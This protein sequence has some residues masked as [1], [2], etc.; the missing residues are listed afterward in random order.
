MLV[1]L[2]YRYD[3]TAVVLFW[4]DVMCDDVVWVMLLWLCCRGYAIDNIWL[5]VFDV[6]ICYDCVIIVSCVC[7]AVMVFMFF[8]RWFMIL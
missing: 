7:V 2:C 3:I 6:K 1:W 5:E 4:S 8:V